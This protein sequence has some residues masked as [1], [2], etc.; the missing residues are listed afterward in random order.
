MKK[1]VIK[2]TPQKVQSMSH[3]GC[4]AQG[5]GCTKKHG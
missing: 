4:C 5:G 3:P 2:W 1:I